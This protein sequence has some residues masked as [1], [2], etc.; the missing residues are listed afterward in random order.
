MLCTKFLMDS[1]E[2]WIHMDVMMLMGIDFG[3]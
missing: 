1:A 3:L 2:G